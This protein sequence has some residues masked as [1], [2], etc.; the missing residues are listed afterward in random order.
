MMTVVHGRLRY[1]ILCAINER[2]CG[3]AFRHGF[4]L[5][6]SSIVPQ[7]GINKSVIHRD[8]FNK[9]VGTICNAKKLTVASEPS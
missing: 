7:Y 2:P 9:S 1:V 6:M 5:F 4:W 3:M 8:T